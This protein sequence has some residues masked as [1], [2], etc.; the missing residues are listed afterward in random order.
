M[1]TE[2]SPIWLTYFMVKWGE[3]MQ[4]E[5]DQR[6]TDCGRPMKRTEPF[7]DAKGVSYE[8]YVCHPDKRVTWLKVP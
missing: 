6:C 4:F 5:S 2:V 1:K 3:V 8:G 7:T